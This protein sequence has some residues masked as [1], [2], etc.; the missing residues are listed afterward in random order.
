MLRVAHE[1]THCH[2]G[3]YC[4]TVLKVLVVKEARQ[5]LALADE[6]AVKL[7]PTAVN[8]GR[9]TP[10]GLLSRQDGRTGLGREPRR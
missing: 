6:P 10:T 1:V 7:L 2:R 4:Q 3:G 5:A 9:K 8:Q